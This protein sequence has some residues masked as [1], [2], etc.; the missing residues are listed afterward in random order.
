MW[1]K[2][3]LELEVS[4]LELVQRLSYVLL[5]PLHDVF[6]MGIFAGDALPASLL[7][8]AGDAILGGVC[9]QLD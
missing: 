5:V 3:E 4:A 8:E 7:A 2:L 9:S 1:K 6:E